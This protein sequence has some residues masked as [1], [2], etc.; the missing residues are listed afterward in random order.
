MKILIVD[1]SRTMRTLLGSFARSIPEA[2]V[3]DAADGQQALLQ[4]AKHQPFDLVLLDWDM[5]VMNGL[6]T[7]KI[8]RANPSY[9]SMKIMMVTAQS[10][11]ESVTEAIECG[12]S[13]YLMKPLNEEMFREKLQLLEL[14]A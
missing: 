1:D 11:M 5:P 2:E 4:I 9:E 8:L 12:A 7:L 3:F 10:G 6:E 14:I 13:D